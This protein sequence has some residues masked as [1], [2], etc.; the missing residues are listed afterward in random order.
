MK[1]DLVVVVPGIMG[2]TLT[3]EGVDVWDIS[4]QALRGLADP[5]AAVERLRLQSGIGDGEPE[6]R[7]ALEVGEPIR[8]LRQLPDLGGHAGHG[9]LA[10][11]LG[12]D[13]RR[14]AV[15]TYD[16]RL[17]NRNSAQKLKTFVERHLSRW[18]ETADPRHYPEA[19]RNAKVVFLC[20]SMG[21]LVVRYYLE[22]CGGREVA[23]SVVTLGTP[24]QG[25]VKTMRMLTGHASGLYRPWRS[26]IRDVCSTYPS[27]GQLLPTYDAV[28]NDI[29]GR[30][31]LEVVMPI[32]GVSSGMVEDASRFADDINT[33]MEKNEEAGAPSYE[34]V[35]VGGARHPTTYGVRHGQGRPLTYLDRSSDSPWEAADWFG[36]GTVPKRS[37][38]PPAMDEKTRT[39]WYGYRHTYL[40]DAGPVMR[41]MRRVCDG[42]PLLR[43]LAD[44]DETGI[45]LPDTVSAGEEFEV[46]ATRADA[47]RKLVVQRLTED[48]RIVAE[49]PMER[50]GD[51]EFR[52]LLQTEPGLWIIQVASKTSD[53]KCSD[54]V[55]AL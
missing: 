55:L 30:V 51:G 28:E 34:L 19:A 22:A 20:R 24:Y 32:D 14:L 50:C 7:Y 52:A 39:L 12:I 1:H 53:Y 25:S 9:N 54:T 42:Q 35:V 5:A 36:D 43:E 38:E 16:W 27:M 4:F 41:Q 26:L 3:R 15:F 29:F 21:G 2:T 10:K 17:S 47:A 37:A 33:A 13:P 11:R 48:G 31:P 46:R 45:E 40:F 8:T 18:Q 49:V 44:D 6:D 23:R